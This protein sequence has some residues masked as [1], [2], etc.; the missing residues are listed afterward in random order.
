MYNHP[1]DEMLLCTHV[2]DFFLSA[3]SLSLQVAR[4][5]YDNYTMIIV[6]LMI[7]NSSLLGLLLVLILFGIEML[8]KCIFP[9]L[10]L[11]T[12]CLSKNL[13]ASCAVRI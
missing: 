3:T 6:C 4:L 13:L 11:S 10:L 8:V 12:V 1:P 7:V 2:N 5:F 9:R